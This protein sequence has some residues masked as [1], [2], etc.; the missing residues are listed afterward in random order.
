MGNYRL[1]VKTDLRLPS[2]RTCIPN[3]SFLLPHY[4]WSHPAALA[5]LFARKLWTTLRKNL[6]NL[7]RSL[8]RLRRIS[9]PRFS[10]ACGLMENRPV[11][12]VFTSPRPPKRKDFAPFNEN[13]MYSWIVPAAGETPLVENPPVLKL[14]STSRPQ[15]KSRRQA[16]NSAFPWFPH[17]L[18]LLLTLYSI[19]RLLL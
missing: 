3:S 9:I 15:G 6:Q 7:P 10:T 1:H 19:V 18:L 2:N 13:C 16:E 17:P 8:R 14:L 5:P 11:H 4:L 12:P